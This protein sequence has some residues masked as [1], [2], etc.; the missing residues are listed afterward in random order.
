MKQQNFAKTSGSKGMQLYGP[1]NT[2]ASFADTK[3]LARA[4]AEHLETEH[5]DLVVH[6]MLKSLRK[7]KVLVDWSQN[8]EHKTTVNVYSLRAKEQPTVS[9]PVS[10]EEVEAC[11]K[12]K[13]AKRLVFTTTDVLK[14]V[15]KMGD[16]F[17]PVASLKQKLPLRYSK[18]SAFTGSKRAAK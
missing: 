2:P 1:L 10:W 6:R 18:R 9:T 8:D 15:G 7:G 16:L 11:L 13:D 12:K 17:A 5:P 4:L 3:A 14:R